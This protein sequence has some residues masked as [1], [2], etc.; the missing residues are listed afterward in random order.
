MLVITI[1]GKFPFSYGFLRGFPRLSYDFPIFLQ[2]SY[3]FPGLRI[4]SSAQGALLGRIWH[5]LAELTQ[6]LVGIAWLHKSSS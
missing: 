3:D 5:R 1:S 2:F 6:G 4:A